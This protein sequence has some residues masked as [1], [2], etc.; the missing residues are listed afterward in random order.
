MKAVSSAAHA[1][2]DSSASS[3]SSSSSSNGSSSSNDNNNNNNIKKIGVFISKAAATR[4][5]KQKRENPAFQQMAQSSSHD[6]LASTASQATDSHVN[7]PSANDASSLSIYHTPNS[8][9][10]ISDTLPNPSRFAVA[11]TPSAVDFPGAF[12]TKPKLADPQHTAALNKF[13]IIPNAMKSKVAEAVGGS[14]ANVVD[15]VYSFVSYVNP[16]ASSSPAESPPSEHPDAVLQQSAADAEAAAR[17]RAR[18]RT[19]A[20]EPLRSAGG[21]AGSIGAVTPPTPDS[22][23]N[24][25]KPK[26]KN[27]ENEDDENDSPPSA[28]MV[29]QVPS[30]GTSVAADL[31]EQCLADANANNPEHNRPPTPTKGAFARMLRLPAAPVTDPAKQASNAEYKQAVQKDPISRNVSQRTG[32]RFKPGSEEKRRYMRRLSKAPQLDAP[33]ATSPARR[34]A[35]SQNRR[36]SASASASGQAEAVAK[37]RSSTLSSDESEMSEESESDDNS[38]DELALDEADFLPSD[39]EQFYHAA[40]TTQRTESKTRAVE[41]WRFIS[42]RVKRVKRRVLWRLFLAQ[43]ITPGVYSEATSRMIQKQRQMAG[44]QTVANGQARPANAGT[45][46]SPVISPQQQRPEAGSGAATGSLAVAAAA[47]AHTQLGISEHSVPASPK[48]DA[49][50]AV[51]ADVSNTGSL[52]RRMLET[53]TMRSNS[54]NAGAEHKD[55]TDMFKKRTP[56]IAHSVESHSSVPSS[57]I[58]AHSNESAT[59]QKNAIWAMEFSVCGKY[60][61][62]GGQDGVV[63]IWRIAPF[64]REQDREKKQNPRSPGSASPSPQKQHSPAQLL[65]QM[66]G[67]G[68][69]QGQTQAQ[70]QAAPPAM[71]RTRTA[72]TSLGVVPD[73]GPATVGKMHHGRQQSILPADGADMMPFANSAPIAR[74]KHHGRSFSVGQSNLSSSSAAHRIPLPHAQQDGHVA[75]LQQV[76][77]PATVSEDAE[78][79]ACAAGTEPAG[80]V[81]LDSARQKQSP[82]GEQTDESCG[83]ACTALVAAQLHPMHAYELLEPVPFRSYVGH[84]ADILSLSWSKNGFLLSASMDRTVRLWH[85]H[86]PEC[87][88]TFRHRDIVTSVAFNP[89]DDRLFISGSLDCRLRLWDIPARGVRQWTG[90]PEGQMVTTVGF[91]SPRGDH[92]VAGTYRGMCVF[93]STDGLAVLGRMHARS[94]R[95]RNA[96]GSKITGFSFAPTG[97][98][99]PAMARRLLGPAAQETLSSLE[100]KNYQLLVSSNDS[101][102]RMFLPRDRK[103]QRKYKGH[104]NASSQSYARLSSDAR[105]IVSGSEDHNIYVWSVAQDNAATVATHPQSDHIRR[106]GRVAARSNATAA[107]E[108]RALPKGPGGGGGGSSSSIMDRKPLLATLFGKRRNNQGGGK[109]AAPHA[110]K[111]PQPDDS[112]EWES[113]DG[114][115]EEKSIYEYFPAHDAAVSQALFAPA[116]TLQYLADHEDP[117]LSRPKARFTGAN[118]EVENIP[119]AS[120]DGTFRG[121]ASSS[122]AAEA[123][124]AD[125]MVEDM[126]AIIVSADTFGNIRVFRKDINMRRRHGAHSAGVHG[127]SRTSLLKAKESLSSLSRHASKHSG[128]LA[129]DDLSGYSMS[130]S[131]R[132]TMS[133]KQADEFQRSLLAAQ[134]GSESPKALNGSASAR[135]VSSFWGRLGRRMSQKRSSSSTFAG[136]S[137]AASTNDDGSGSLRLRA[138]AVSGGGGGGGDEQP[139]MPL[140]FP[141][142]PAASATTVPPLAMLPASGAGGLATRTGGDVCKYCGHAQFLEFAV[143]GS[144]EADSKQKHRGPTLLV[145]KHCKRVKDMPD[146]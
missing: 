76:P 110:E 146:Q 104:A 133:Q 129:A 138:R 73:S 103:V 32:L 116:A 40:A 20:N 21:D 87:L 132:G 108:A 24:G 3:S 126:T 106:V 121:D 53:A 94:S 38:N 43:E 33:E 117:I 31:D 28:G 14:L 42:P 124:E 74:A 36:R 120:V 142:D 37:A 62:A 54:N 98:L 47:A 139:H 95:G 90:L 92:I 59:A 10:A 12:T 80:D 30:G 15:G 19:K 128:G 46:S 55:P 45:P 9:T 39:V 134:Q 109:E 123:E 131:R 125:R 71:P 68:Q 13:T 18:T 4:S 101:R 136:I 88:C 119:G 82:L 58:R 102:L 1:Q 79:I 130:Q 57:I 6:P 50:G 5:T 144:A 64:A 56:S 65:P 81:P 143:A 34:S 35:S 61:A 84:A 2:K 75:G 77:V 27:N 114:K 135:P 11:R 7:T 93:Y 113:L 127:G 48:R 29:L 118:G 26:A 140:V 91:T 67:Q 52:R 141:Q 70:G 107:A 99:P 122:Q 100:S 66:Q 85:P 69:A 16:L 63:R 78:H 86:R 112:A 105:Y 145:C 96:K 115:V 23:D 89:R 72:T 8:P 51:G 111:L 22:I 97:Q 49:S 44:R 25:A 137:S 41:A 83:D 60:L 17:A